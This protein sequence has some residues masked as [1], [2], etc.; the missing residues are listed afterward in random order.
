MKATQRAYVIEKGTIKHETRSRDLAGDA[1]ARRATSAC[2]ALPLPSG[3][4]A[5]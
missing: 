5:G 4:R 1:E 3:E 2:D